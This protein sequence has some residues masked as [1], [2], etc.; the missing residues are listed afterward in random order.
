[1][2]EEKEISDVINLT[3]SEFIITAQTRKKEKNNAITSKISKQ[4]VN[5]DLFTNI[6]GE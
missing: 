2:L 5:S 3:K 6:I 1:M 4:R